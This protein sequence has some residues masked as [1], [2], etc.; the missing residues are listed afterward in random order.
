MKRAQVR[1]VVVLERPERHG[2]RT[3]RVRLERENH[4][5]L[6]F[7]AGHARRNLSHP[8]FTGHRGDPHL[9]RQL[10]RQGSQ[11]EPFFTLEGFELDS[12]EQDQ[13]GFR[14]G[15]ALDLDR[16]AQLRA[17]EAAR[18]RERQR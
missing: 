1:I 5:D 12:L 7:E 2:I 4:A 10:S 9:R 3:G 15:L 13:A 17:A 6:V 8:L 11:V 18:C 16:F 14:A